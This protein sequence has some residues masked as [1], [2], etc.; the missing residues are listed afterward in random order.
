LIAG[1]RELA[2]NFR[3]RRDKR[4]LLAASRRVTG[5]SVILNN[6]RYISMNYR[7]F[8]GLSSA[9][10]SGPLEHISGG[11][12]PSVLSATLGRKQRFGLFKMPLLRCL[13]EP[14]S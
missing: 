11:P 10:K 2:T 6:Y 3:S 14:V 9:F 4:L 13:C 7:S 5:T 8:F 12:V 1:F